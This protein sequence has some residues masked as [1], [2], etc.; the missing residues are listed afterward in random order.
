M[1]SRIDRLILVLLCVSLPLGGWLLC[2]GSQLDIIHGALGYG[3]AALGGLAI[4]FLARWRKISWPTRVIV[5]GTVPA[6]FLGFLL[7]W[8]LNELRSEV[9]RFVEEA[10][11]A[12][13]V[14]EAIYLYQND[15]RLWPTQ[16]SELVPR[17]LKRLPERA[18]SM[19]SPWVLVWRGY[20]DGPVL[21]A[22]GPH[23]IRLF[24]EFPA[25][26]KSN[27]LGRWLATMDN[28][29]IP[30][31]V[32]QPAPPAVESNDANELRLII[33]ELGRRVEEHPDQSTH[34]AELRRCRR[35][36]AEMMPEESAGKG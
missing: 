8:T 27:K 28:M 26:R 16:L 17:Y 3:G 7:Y 6:M 14:V 36:L 10:H 13:D 1:V 30:C 29:P 20:Y 5:A 24:Y 15:H 32:D 34:A 25:N 23:N 31:E 11:H 18:R 2:A 35:R 19:T 4:V 12:T 9:V 33:D 21:I 22:N